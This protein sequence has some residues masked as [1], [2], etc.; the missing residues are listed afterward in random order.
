[1]Y[2]AVFYNQHD[3][4]YEKINIPKISSDEILLETKICGLC[5]SDLVK[6]KNNQLKPSTV[7]G[8]EVAGIIKECGN[9]VIEFKKGDRVV[10]A[11]HTPCFNCHYCFHENYSM[12]RHFK[13]INFVPGAFSQFIKIPS[14]LVKNTTFKI[15][16]SLSFEKAVF[17]EPLACCLKAIKKA[18][19][20]KND[21]V[22]ILGLGSIG[23]LLTQLCKVFNFNT[24]GIDLKVDRLELANSLGARFTINAMSPDL[25]EQI[26]KITNN[27]GADLVILAAESSKT[28][29]TSMDIVRDGGK[30]CV[31]SS[32]PPMEKI[33][34]DFNSIYYKEICIY[35]S[36]SPDPIDLKNSLELIIK[37]DIKLE[38]LISKIFPLEKI[39]EAIAL[40]LNKKFIKILLRP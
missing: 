29:Y 32:I 20:H 16:D 31:F 6:I 37:E 34:L 15:P 17:T 22:V 1:M 36:Y 4:R 23:L 13:N 24:I 35:G 5:G 21:T 19:L 39:K 18:N 14:E 8:H 26:L 27:I 33:E 25:K 9:N 11:H 30:I 38:P 7:I 10:V 2:A 3:I 28:F 40:A 12:C